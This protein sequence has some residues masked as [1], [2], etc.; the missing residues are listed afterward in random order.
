M[1]G[2]IVRTMALLTLIAG[3]TVQLTAA[4]MPQIAGSWDVTSVTSPDF[5]CKDS[6]PGDTQ[7]YIWIVSS[8]TDGTVS[9]SVQGETSYPKLE[10]RWSRDFRTLTLQGGATGQL[11]GSASSWLKLSFNGAGSLTGIRRVLQANGRPCFA[12]F[13]ITAKKR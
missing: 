11:G 8:K 12:D 9:V 1:L 7:A 4:D 5:T 10:G 2:S 3:L 6:K 13:E